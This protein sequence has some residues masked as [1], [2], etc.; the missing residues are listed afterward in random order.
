MGESANDL[1][2]DGKSTSIRPDSTSLAGETQGAEPL[3]S[4]PLAYI[5]AA[6][7]LAGGVRV[8]RPNPFRMTQIPFDSPE[9][10]GLLPVKES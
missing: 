6:D 4:G 9:A 2:E 8:G 7:S 10:I 1:N 3:A 5:R